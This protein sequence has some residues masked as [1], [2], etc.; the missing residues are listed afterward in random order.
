MMVGAGESPSARAADRTATWSTRRAVIGGLAG[1]LL[2]F[3]GGAVMLPLLAFILLV[4]VLPASVAMSSRV[5]LSLPLIATWLTAATVAL[6]VVGAGL[7]PAPTWVPLVIVLAGVRTPPVAQPVAL[8]RRVVDLTPWIAALAGVCFL[9][10]SAVV[11]IS[12]DGRRGVDQR[13]SVMA[14]AEDG[15]SHLSIA[16]AVLVGGGLAYGKEARAI[17]SQWQYP[18]GFHIG[19]ASLVRALEDTAGTS[20]VRG[21]RSDAIWVAII[22]T[23]GMLVAAAGATAGAVARRFGAG[24]AST[25][26]VSFAASFAMFWWLPFTLLMHF[27][28]PQMLAL[29]MLLAAITAVVEFRS[30]GFGW[31]ITVLATAFIGIAWSWY[32]VLPIALLVVVAWCVAFARQL[33]GR[34]LRVVAAG[35]LAAAAS[36]LPLYYSLQGVDAAVINTTGGVAEIDPGL[37]LGAAIACVALLIALGSRGEHRRERVALTVIVAAVAAFTYALGRY[38][39]QSVGDTAYFYGKSLYTVAIVGVSVLF[40]LL[41][42]ALAR[43]DMSSRR[44]MG[45]L[46][47]LLVMFAVI[48]DIRPF[49]RDESNP[50]QYRDHGNDSIHRASFARYVDAM[51]TIEGRYVVQWEQ[52][53]QPVVDYTAS[54]WLTTLNRRATD[55]IWTFW[56]KVVQ[57]QDR[58][59]LADFVNETDGN[60]AILTT[61]RR[62]RADLFDAGAERGSLD[63]V[64]MIP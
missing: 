23:F 42:A 8:G 2:A 40:G 29:V 15:A 49:S 24:V 47:T 39:E 31:T 54:R 22:I 32:F 25:A 1:L 63:K 11:D 26:V 5:L 53:G 50:W 28:G 51:P 58:S 62:L 9:L 17:S 38:Q 27:F 45:V 6:R 46:V 60:V 44:A 36:A 12:G 3:G 41:A 30:L 64:V 48:G 35:V 13:I 55:Q 34:W 59:K 52:T 33:R 10:S 37:A 61:N 7:D 16:D 21:G 56:F 57:E 4:R 20:D 14:S 43:T 19:V 18:P